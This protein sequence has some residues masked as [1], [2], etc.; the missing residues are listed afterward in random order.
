MNGHIFTIIMSSVFWRCWLG[1]SKG[2]RPVKSTVLPQQCSWLNITAW[3]QRAVPSKEHRSRVLSY[4]WLGNRK[5]MWLVKLFCNSSWKF[6][7]G[8]QPNGVFMFVFKKA[9]NFAQ[10]GKFSAHTHSVYQPIFQSYSSLGLSPKVNSW[11]LLWQ[12]FYWLYC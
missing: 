10:N 3:W 9:Y 4:C 1:D 7:F 11:D 12:Y 2:I 5:G 6:T 8:D